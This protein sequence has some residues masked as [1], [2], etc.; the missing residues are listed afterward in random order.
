MNRNGE[1]QYPILFHL[2]EMIQS[3]LRVIL[4][5]LLYMPFART[6]EVS[7]ILSLLRFFNHT[8]SIEFDEVQDLYP[9]R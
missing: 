7:V 2:Q 6:A 5:C 9:L 8:F 3:L 1:T 4:L